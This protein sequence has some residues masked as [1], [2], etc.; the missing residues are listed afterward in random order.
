[1]SQP[2]RAKRCNTSRSV[3]RVTPINSESSRSAGKMEPGGKR[4]F[5]I[6]SIIY[7]SAK[8]AGLFAD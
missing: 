8:P 6:L 7:F 4:P 1:M 3:V 2:S 5:Q